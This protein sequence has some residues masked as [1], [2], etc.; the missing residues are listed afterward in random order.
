[1]QP[2]KIFRWLIF[3][4]KIMQYH[5]FLFSIKKLSQILNSRKY[6]CIDVWLVNLLLKIYGLQ[7]QLFQRMWL[8]YS[9]PLRGSTLTSIMAKQKLFHTL[10]ANK[11]HNFVDTNMLNVTCLLQ[12]HIEWSVKNLLLQE[13]FLR[14][15]WLK[16]V[17]MNFQRVCKNA[18]STSLLKEL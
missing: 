2:S 1:M 4:P 12:A 17:E 9:V 18:K 7:R 6:N 14:I 8:F 5:Y 11:Q 16:C 3:R 15:G 10:V 13:K